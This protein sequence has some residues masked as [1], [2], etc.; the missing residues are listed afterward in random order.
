ML[1]AIMM[2]LGLSVALFAND[3][4]V[5]EQNTAAQQEYV[6]LD[7]EE[8]HNFVNTL[9]DLDFIRQDLHSELFDS[10]GNMIEDNLESVNEKFQSRA[11]EAIENNGLTIEKYSQYA[12]LLETNTDFQQI[13][14][15]V[16]AQMQQQ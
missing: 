1:K 10:E 14:Q 11:V 5:P 13:V 7:Q 12:Q 8:V 9:I 4:M 2:T 15:Q 6:E 3:A 16:V